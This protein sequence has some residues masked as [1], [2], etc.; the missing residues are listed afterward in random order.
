MEVIDQCVRSA[1]YG[2][3]RGT[4]AAWERGDDE[5]SRCRL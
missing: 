4:E 3:A 2:P 1:I 5:R